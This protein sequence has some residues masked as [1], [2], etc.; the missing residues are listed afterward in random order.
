MEQSGYKQMQMIVNGVQTWE[1][2]KCACLVGGK[3]L[4]S[5]MLLHTEGK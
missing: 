1:D 2:K 5:Q 4:K 3:I